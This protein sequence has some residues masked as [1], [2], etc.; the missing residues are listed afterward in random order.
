MA[1]KIAYSSKD[2][3]MVTTGDGATQLAADATNRPVEEIES[4]MRLSEVFLKMA[5]ATNHT[6]EQTF[7]A[8]LNVIVYVLLQVM[9]AEERTQA[10]GV[11]TE[12]LCAAVNGGGGKQ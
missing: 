12:A 7:N 1:G 5:M 11:L 6:P 10:V 2:M 8:A 9:D 4:I 3:V